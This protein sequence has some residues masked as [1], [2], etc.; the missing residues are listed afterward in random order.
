MNYDETLQ[1]LY[2]QLPVFQHIGNAA[3]K[4][5]FDNVIKILN[6]L[7]N[8]QTHFKTI[9]IAGTN[10]KGSVSHF[11]A[12]I[13]QAAGYKVG[14]YTSPH[15]VDFGERIRVNGEKIDKQY[16]V[17]FVKNY[18]DF[19]KEIH[20]SF[21]EVAT[22]MAF[23]YF[24]FCN[25]DVGVIEVGLGGRLDST[26]VIQSALSV[27]TNISFDHEA[28]LGHTLEEIAQEKAGIIK[29]MTPVVIGESHPETKPVFLERAKEM[30]A[31]IFFADE[32]Y[33]VFFKKYVC[34]K[35]EVYT[36]DHS[37]FRVGICGNY[38]LKNI[39]TLL[40][41]VQQLKNL[42]F[43]I[44][45]QALQEGLEFV[46]E[47]TGLQGRWQQIQSSPR[48]ILDTGHNLGGIRYVAEQLENQDCKN[49]RIVFGMV[50]DKDIDGVLS[51][52]P[53]KALYYFTQAAI[54]RALPAEIVLKKANRYDLNGKI[55]YSV[56]EAVLNALMEAEPDDLIF[57]G[58]SNYIVGEALQ[59]FNK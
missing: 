11:L 45:E 3:Y 17:D 16:V 56:A 53:K 18:Q 22:S 34:N 8:P 59:F 21:F 14:L 43:E 55:Y 31:P 10:G 30:N 40:A 52:M 25:I 1:Y 37:N 39:A 23:D 35:M 54:H 48:V 38:Q 13:L 26:N 51:L 58:G 19:I 41:T 7:H 12:A 44:P 24:S 47:L 49:L 5:G 50:N 15:L 2:N 29:P 6:I 28:L 20:P 57:I 36:S 42:H 27:I 4:P 46:T 9:H 33:Q 32:L